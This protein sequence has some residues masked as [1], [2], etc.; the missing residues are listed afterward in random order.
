MSTV[1][2]VLIT[3]VFATLGVLIA[4]PVVALVQGWLSRREKQANVATMYHDLLSDSERKRLEL[5]KTHSCL[6]RRHEKDL[7]ALADVHDALKMLREEVTWS[8]PSQ[9]EKLEAPLRVLRKIIDR[10]R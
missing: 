5:Q 4:G 6:E 2:Q 7:R 3:G 9:A 1:S 8:D 10:P